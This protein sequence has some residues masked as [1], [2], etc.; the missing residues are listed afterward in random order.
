VPDLFHSFGLRDVEIDLPVD[1]IGPAPYLLDSQR[2][3]NEHILI[4][5]CRSPVFSGTRWLLFVFIPIAFFFPQLILPLLL[6]PA[7][8]FRVDLFEAPL[9]GFIGRLFSPFSGRPSLRGPPRV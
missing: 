3:M 4:T 9:T 8:S 2:R 5:E 6:F 1:F 7:F